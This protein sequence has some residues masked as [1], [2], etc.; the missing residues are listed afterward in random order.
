MSIPMT[1]EFIIKLITHVIHTSK[2]GLIPKQTVSIDKEGGLSLSENNPYTFNKAATKSEPAS[3]YSY[4]VMCLSG[5]DDTTDDI[6][7]QIAY[8][9]DADGNPIEIPLEEYEKDHKKSSLNPEENYYVFFHVR[10]K[11]KSTT[12]ETIVKISFTDIKVI[13]QRFTK[14]KPNSL[15]ECKGPH[16]VF[17]YKLL[18]SY[19]PEDME[20]E[21]NKLNLVEKVISNQSRYV[22]N[23][24]DIDEIA[25]RNNDRVYRYFRTKVGSSQTLSFREEDEYGRLLLS[26]MF[27]IQDIFD[28]Y[29][30]TRSDIALQKLQCLLRG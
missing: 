27:T 5:K 9:A 25:I 2:N 10:K 12:Y 21:I 29:I 11:V 30:Y 23:Y 16:V 14:Y 7:R 6:I 20:E 28:L 19:Y 24:K 17:M 18:Q 1:P 3:K 26:C 22:K 15:G 13:F 8:T 4:T